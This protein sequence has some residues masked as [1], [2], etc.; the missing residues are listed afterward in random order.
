VEDDDLE[1]IT[2]GNVQAALEQL[3]DSYVRPL[4]F[5]D[6]KEM[7]IVALGSGMSLKSLKPLLDEFN[8][9]PERMRGFAQLTD[10][11]SLAA[12]VNRHKRP[13]SILFLDDVDPKE[14]AVHVVFDAHEPTSVDPNAGALPGWGE[15]GARYNFPLTPEWK[16]WRDVAGKWLNQGEF[17]G[18]IEQHVLEVIDPTDPGERARALAQELGLSLAGKAKLFEL[19]RGLKVNV[20]QGVANA[21]NLATG[22]GQVIFEEKHT[23]AGGETLRVPG[24]FAVAVPVFRGGAAYRM[25]VMLRYRIEERHLK[26]QL[27]PH[28]IDQVFDDA[29][30]GAAKQLRE[31]TALPVFRGR[32]S[33]ELQR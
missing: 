17:A 3:R 8:R 23:G 18:F 32:P 27:A 33:R 15:F 11:D 28:L 22:E 14:P 10:L 26:W 1:P 31:A 29:L 30:E 6:G 9:Y 25:I 16:A 5:D 4:Q 13:E 21:V 19:S 7:P 24:A 12:Y 20:N 2:L